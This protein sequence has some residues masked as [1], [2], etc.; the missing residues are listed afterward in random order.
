MPS[1]V[2]DSAL[3][4]D[5]FGTPEMRAVFSDEA[6]LQACLDTEAALARAQASVGMIPIDAAREITAKAQLPCL[7]MARLKT[8]CENV[9]YPIVGLATQ[10]AHVCAGEAGGYVHWGATTQD[11]M[12]TAVVLQVRRA[13]ELV[14]ADLIQYIVLLGDLAKRHRDVPMAG[15]THLQHALPITF[16]YKVAIWRDPLVRHL[17][18]LRQMRPRVLA[19]QLGGAAGTLASLGK[20]RHAVRAAMTKDLGLAEPDISWHVSRDG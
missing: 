1:T 14:E 15:R 16:G 4:R 11:I 12:D 7:D 20:D 5:M 13:L 3:F 8:E 6:Y 18:R 9:G 17:E 19:G 2:Y 10:L